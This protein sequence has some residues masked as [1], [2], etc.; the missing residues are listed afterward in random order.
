M[1]SISSL[2]MLL[3]IPLFGN[4]AY[5]IAFGDNAPECGITCLVFFNI[6]FLCLFL[7]MLFGNVKD[8]AFLKGGAFIVATWYLIIEIIVAILFLSNKG[9]ITAA[10]LTQFLL[11]GIFLICFFRLTSTNER[12]ERSL[13]ETQ[14]SRSQEMSQA[15]LNL[16]LALNSLKDPRDKERVRALLSEINS[17]PMHSTPTTAELEKQICEKIGYISSD[18]QPYHYQEISN[19]LKQRRT[20]LFN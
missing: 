8:S 2:L 1:N 6:S 4:G 17:S 20:L 10:L 19:L 11:L 9:S 16:Q 13:Q 5:F 15:R 12:T 14:K 18:S 7:P 3:C